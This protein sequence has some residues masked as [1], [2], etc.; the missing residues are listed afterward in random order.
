MHIPSTKK[1]DVS[2]S[3][4]EFSDYGYF[5]NGDDSNLSGEAE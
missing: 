1:V 4:I 5:S 3:F 2:I